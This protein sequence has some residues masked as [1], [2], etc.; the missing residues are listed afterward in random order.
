M[1][2]IH[3]SNFNKFSS[4]TDEE[5]AFTIARNLELQFSVNL[6]VDYKTE[7]EVNNAVRNFLNVSPPPPIF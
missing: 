3:I 2:P 5:K 4:Y 1:S 7:R 6:I